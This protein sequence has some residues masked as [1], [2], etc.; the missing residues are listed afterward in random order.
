MTDD[1]P[2]FPV[3]LWDSR[4]FSIAGGQMLDYRLARRLVEKPAMSVMISQ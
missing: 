1:S 3:E 2:I 4:V